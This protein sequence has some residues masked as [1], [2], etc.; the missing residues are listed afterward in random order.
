M[1]YIEFEERSFTAK[2]Q[3][4]IDRVN[5]IIADYNQQGYILTLRQ[6]YYQLVARGIIENQERSYKN[7]INLVNDGRIAGLIPWD[8]IEDRAREFNSTYTNEDRRECLANIEQFYTVDLWARQDYYVEVWVEKEALGNVIERACD[9]WRVPHM[10]CKGYLSASQ[11]WRAGERFEAAC[12]GR[13]GVLIHLGDHDPSGID[14]T[15]DNETRLG[16][17]SYQADID[18]RRIALNMPQ[19][20]QYNPPPNPAK[21]TDT[22]A[23]KYIALHGDQSW[24]LDALE[25][26]VIER[27]IVKEIRSLIDPDEWA[28]GI[29]E[30]EESRE[31]LKK[32][33][34]NWEEIEPFVEGL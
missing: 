24:E 25:P 13:K 28:K 17:F 21:I 4:M 31:F 8:M 16:L 23:D 15:R 2:S 12:R 1:R 7:L 19:V 33:Y 22:R 27:L 3:A 14:M 18:V 30:E 20:R 34:N 26:S 10:A 5:Q 29:E 9:P 11:A 6:I 32:F